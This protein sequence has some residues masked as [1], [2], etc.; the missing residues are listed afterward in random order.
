[1]TDARLYG[2][3]R[4]IEFVREAL[5][6]NGIPDRPLP[7]ML[8]VGPRGSG[9]SAMLA[10]LWSELSADCLSAHLDLASAQGVEDI[11]FAAMHGLGRKIPGIRPIAFPRLM[12]SFKALSFADDGGGRAAFDAYLRG[13]GDAAFRAALNDWADRAAPLLSSPGQQFLWRAAVKALGGV[14]SFVRRRHE[15]KILHWYAEQIP[16]G[17]RE[18]DPLWELYTWHH[19]KGDEPARKVGRTVCAA[20]LADLRSDFNDA[21]I[22]HGQRH[23]NCLLLAD[24]CG[25]KTGDLFLE[26]LAECR[27]DSNRVGDAP[28]PA[29]VVAVQ[30]G[31]MRRRRSRPIDATDDRLAFSTPHPYAADADH[32]TWW[33]PVRLTDLSDKD[34]GEITR[35]S[36]LGSN[37]R[38]ADVIHALTGG[39]PESADRLATLL[40]LFG[41]ASFDSRQLLVERLPSAQ[42]LPDDWPEDDGEETT[43]EEYLLKRMFT[44]DLTVAG[45]GSID[46]EDN[47]TL[48]AMAVLSATPGL[49]PGACNA[50]LQYLGRTQVDATTAQE[51]LT[52]A[53]W[54]E[55]TPEGD[56][57]PLH[58]LARL[59]LQRWLARRPEAWRDAHKGYAA[60]Y[61]RPQDIVIRHYH[62]LAQVEPSFPD[63]LT[64]VIGFLDRQFTECT[65]RQEWL[66]LLDQVTAAPNRCRTTRDPRVFV[67][68]LAEAADPGSA[69]QTIRRLTVARWLYNDRCFD[70][71]RKL[72]QLIAHEYDY[73]AA[74]CKDDSEVL[75]RQSAKYRRIEHTWEG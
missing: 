17:I 69:H 23:S 20:L 67:T 66:D 32:P 39:H 57:G 42:A 36:V 45:D 58:P 28:D 15:A 7:I 40:A 71:A 50:A 54:L 68:T 19:E 35:S 55:E 33:Y 8:L 47:P 18:Y 4:I 10:G 74:L 44:G 27:R 60:A 38:D 1:M 30:R 16:G 14:F 64:M 26:L 46:A 21:P 2:R 6:R 53:M 52:A 73:L 25:G 48:T 65:S 34:V 37:S 12:L 31:R 75:F 5:Q 51:R 61:S 41:R 56:P 13:T 22:R 9:G 43:V 70:P 11:V 63:P 24:N 29:L 59:L 62:H 49:R 72:A 3:R